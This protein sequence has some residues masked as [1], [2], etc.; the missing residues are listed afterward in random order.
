MIS[1]SRV[2]EN[3]L[4]S[5]PQTYKRS[6]HS[7]APLPYLTKLRWTQHLA[8]Y[9]RTTI[10]LSVSTRETSKNTGDC[11]PLRLLS[12]SRSLTQCPKISTKASWSNRSRTSSSQFSH[13]FAIKSSQRSAQYGLISL[14]SALLTAPLLQCS[15]INSKQ[16]SPRSTRRSALSRPSARCTNSFSLLRTPT[17]A[18][19]AIVALISDEESLS[20]STTC[21]TSST[22]ST[23]RRSYQERCLS[24]RNR[25]L[26]T[27]ATTTRLEEAAATMVEALDKEAVKAAA[28]ITTARPR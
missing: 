5:S 3:V 6:Q 15:L 22:T 14:S 17:Q 2:P 27:T 1:Y 19:L 12:N 10:R 23:P 8:V 25:T 24:E 13:D 11:V 4:S 16:V 7:L 26:V 28:V 9:A 21:A 20:L 18:M